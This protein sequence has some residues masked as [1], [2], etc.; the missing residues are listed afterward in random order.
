MAQYN[1][2]SVAE[3][4]VGAQSERVYAV[5]SRIA[6][7]FGNRVMFVLGLYGGLCTK[8]T[9]AAFLVEKARWYDYVPHVDLL[10]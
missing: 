2:D 7:Q 8:T 1:V 5:G 3:L 6:D 4:F 9:S 10:S